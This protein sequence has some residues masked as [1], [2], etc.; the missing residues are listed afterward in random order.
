VPAVVGSALLSLKLLL[1]R[2]RQWRG[3]I[4]MAFTLYLGAR[5]NLW[6]CPRCGDTFAGRCG[7]AR[8]F[9]AGQCVHCGL[10]KYSNGEV[11]AALALFRISLSR[12]FAIRNS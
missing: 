11:I 8:E 6:R 5:I 1:L 10:A 7:A 9:F 4:W 2:D 12:N 3:L